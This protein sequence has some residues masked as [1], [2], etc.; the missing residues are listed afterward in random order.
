MM[1]LGPFKNLARVFHFHRGLAVNVGTD[2]REKGMDSK[3]QKRLHETSVKFHR[4]YQIKIQ[5]LC[6]DGLLQKWEIAQT[7]H[8]NDKDLV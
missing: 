4:K 2:K 8:C 6:S 3:Q 7:I 5:L 1:L